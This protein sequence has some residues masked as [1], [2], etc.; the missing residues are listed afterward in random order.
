[1]L[2]LRLAILFLT[3]G[4]TPELQLTVPEKPVAFGRNISCS[5]TATNLT[6]IKSKI[7][8]W[9]VVERKLTDFDPIGSDLVQWPDGTKIWFG[10]GSDDTVVTVTV[11]G[12]FVTNDNQLLIAHASREIIVGAL[13]P[14]PSPTP[15]PS[16]NPPPVPIPTPQPP[17][18]NPTPPNP[19][20][21]NPNPQPA[22]QPTSELGKFVSEH[23]RVAQLPSNESQILANIYKEVADEIDKPG[24]KYKNGNDVIND[25][26]AKT[27]ERLGNNQQKWIDPVLEP[28]HIELNRR[29]PKMRTLGD[30]SKA[31]RDIQA[32]FAA[33]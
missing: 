5:V 20:P 25:V 16:P 17:N 15:N 32:G 23:V 12:A 9:N 21:P 13:P 27:K 22:P 24:S 19:T 28:L 29:A 31:F 30:I 26:V 8:D 33:Q 3:I 11:T 6:N 10:S 14:N 1:M 18:P 7:Y 2:S 4:Q